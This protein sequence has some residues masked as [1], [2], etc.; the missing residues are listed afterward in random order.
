[1]S[2]F[3]RVNPKDKSEIIWSEFIQPSLHSFSAY[4]LPVPCVLGAGNAMIKAKSAPALGDSQSSAQ[5]EGSTATGSMLI[6]D[7]D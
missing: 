4:Q 7:P 3:L 1:M 2:A 6:E 5:T